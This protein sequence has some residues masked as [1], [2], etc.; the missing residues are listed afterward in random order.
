LIEKGSAL[1]AFKV[2]IR[3]MTAKYADFIASSA[4]KKPAPK[5]PEL[6]PHIITKITNHPGF[7]YDFRATV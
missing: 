3:P 4:P 5:K 2:K 6:N 1:A 7:T